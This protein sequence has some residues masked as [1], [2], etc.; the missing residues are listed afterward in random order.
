MDYYFTRARKRIHH[1]TGGKEKTKAAG[2]RPPEVGGPCAQVFG[3]EYGPVEEKDLT[4]EGTEVGA[5]RGTQGAT[6]NFGG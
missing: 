2:L 6:V 3:D 1:T 5:Q 4:T